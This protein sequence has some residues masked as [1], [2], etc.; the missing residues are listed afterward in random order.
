M[1]TLGVKE[2]TCFTVSHSSLARTSHVI[3]PSSEGIR[4]YSPAMCPE[5][6]CHTRND[7]YAQNPPTFRFAFPF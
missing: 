5:R 3:T 1:G 7:Y 6:C 2:V 4:K